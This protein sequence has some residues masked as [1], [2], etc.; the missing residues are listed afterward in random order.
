M[1]E[2]I[3]TIAIFV[4]LISVGIVLAKGFHECHKDEASMKEC[5]ELIDTLIHFSE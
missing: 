1:K 3:K 5:G 4:F 2:T